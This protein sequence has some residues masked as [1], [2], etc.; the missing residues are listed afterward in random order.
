[1]TDRIDTSRP[2]S[3]PIA[4]IAASA[5][6]QIL[7]RAACDQGLY[8]ETVV[9]LEPDEDHA[10]LG[11]SAL[12]GIVSKA[13]SA[14]ETHDASLLEPMATEL[15]WLFPTL[16]ERAWAVG[17]LDLEEI[18]LPPSRRRL[19]KESEIIQRVIVSLIRVLRSWRRTQKGRT[20]FHFHRLH[21]MDEQTV[22]LFRA[23]AATELGDDICILA[24]ASHAEPADTDGGSSLVAGLANGADLRR[25]M[26]EDLVEL[27]SI[28]HL[29]APRP[30]G[31][32]DIRACVLTANCKDPALHLDTAEAR[33]YKAFRS[34]LQTSNSN[35]N[36]CAQDA[37]SASVFTLN[38][39]LALAI[40]TD[41]GNLFDTLSKSDQH[42]LILHLGFAHA[43][44]TDFNAARQALELSIDFASTPRQSAVS[45]F[46]LAL[47]HIKRLKS[48]VQGRKHIDTALSFL[49]PTSVPDANEMAWLQNL[50]A[51]SF[52]EQ[53][54]FTSAGK[55]LQA[56]IQ[57]NSSVPRSSD[58]I[59]LKLNLLNNI[60]LLEELTGDYVRAIKRYASLEPLMARASRNTAK[61]WHYRLGGLLVRHG[62]LEQGLQHLI[63][64]E[65][66]ARSS[67]DLYYSGRICAEIVS[68]K[69]ALGDI[70]Q[71]KR[72][73]ARTNTLQSFLDGARDS[74]I[75]E[76]TTGR[77]PLL[78]STVDVLETRLLASGPAPSSP[79]AVKTRLN[80]PF[81]RINLYRN[82]AA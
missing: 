77:L 66:C 65:H 17:A 40:V 46:H 13:I 29:D 5:P 80:Q 32:S 62:K 56:A 75:A 35:L 16:K 59:H 34:A 71:A 54:D 81:H 73:Q 41:L 7:E 39:P 33:K 27:V 67:E 70:K 37:M 61:H 63:E 30:D 49:D 22:R 51:L 9:R 6:P 47:V 36:Q 58:Q 64:A 38:F 25:R 12:C 15:V 74:S 31:P 3:G 69:H 78:G 68:I 1:M 44:S 21:E 10:L 20:L 19:H 26:L 82:K 57:H 52:V 11:F 43:F 79:A 18:A 42:E 72:W 45:H 50:R 53:R 48:P 76:I 8:F 28:Q 24:S 60:S 55:C 23:L 2:V 4:F 14:L